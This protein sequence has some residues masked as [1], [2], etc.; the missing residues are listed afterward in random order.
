MNWNRGVFSRSN[1]QSRQS[2]PK[3]WADSYAAAFA[4]TSR[5]TVVTFDQAFGHN[6]KELLLLKA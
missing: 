2:A 1:T 3:D 6:S 4:A 5:L